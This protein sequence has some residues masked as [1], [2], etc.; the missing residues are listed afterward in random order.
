MSYASV[1]DLI[2]RYGEEEI[3]QRTDR[4]GAGAIDVAVAQRALID[5]EAEIDGYLAA[6]YRLP[7][8]TTPALL[9]RIAC[10][11]ARYRL[12]E[13]AASEEVRSRYDDARRILE[14]LARGLVSLGLPADLPDAARPQ[15]QLAAAKAGPA[16]VFGRDGMGGY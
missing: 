7:L 1:A 16:P 4:L 8:A 3:Q 6:R 12:W 11:I 14:H 10:D 15:P 9:A 13:D 2:A 5:A